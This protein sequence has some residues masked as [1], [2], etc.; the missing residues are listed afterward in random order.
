MYVSVGFV[1]A[2]ILAIASLTPPIIWVVWWMLSDL[3][4][5]AGA[6]DSAAYVSG[7]S[8]RHLPAA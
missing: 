7:P 3:G 5:R 4:E 1:T 2:I 6:R 8:R